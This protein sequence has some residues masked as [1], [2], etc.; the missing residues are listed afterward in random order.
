MYDLQ[1]EF[2]DPPVAR[3]LTFEVAERTMAD[4]TVLVEPSDAD[5]ERVAAQ[6]EAADAERR[7]PRLQLG[8]RGQVAGG[9]ADADEVAAA[10]QPLDLRERLRHVVAQRAHVPRLRRVLG[11]EEPLG[12]PDRAERPRA[13]VDRVPVADGRELQR[14]AAEIQHDAVGQRRGVH[15]GEVAVPRL[16]LGG[17]DLDLEAAP[18]A[19]GPDEVVVVGGVADRRGRDRPDLLD[20]G[21]A[22]EVRV[23]LERLERALDPLGLELPGR[24]EP[25]PDPDGLVDLVRPLPPAVGV[26]EDDEAERVRAEVDDR[27]RARRGHPSLSRAR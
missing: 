16:L 6:L 27:Q 23:H 1:I 10:A 8:G 17:E 18:F 2:P 15:R 14:A 21:R 5:V 24:V 22:A 4:G 9:A 25:L 12:H 19:R 20:A 7:E 11:G 26:R 13:H 3:E